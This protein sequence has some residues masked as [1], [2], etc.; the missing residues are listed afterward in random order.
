MPGRRTLK[1]LAGFSGSY[2]R[3]VT[4]SVERKGCCPGSVEARPSR[5]GT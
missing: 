4:G 2:S 1:I 5:P 3:A